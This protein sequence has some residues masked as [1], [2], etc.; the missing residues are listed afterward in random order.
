VSCSKSEGVVLLENEP[1]SVGE[2]IGAGR[3]LGGKRLNHAV[4]GCIDFVDRTQ[5][6]AGSSPASSMENRGKLAVFFGTE[7]I[8]N[9]SPSADRTMDMRMVLENLGPHAPYT[10]APGVD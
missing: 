2:G 3:T 8:A 1:Q 4:S 7:R 9:F 5:E 10:R 6:V